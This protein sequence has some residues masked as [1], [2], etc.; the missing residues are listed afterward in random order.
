MRLA[1]ATDPG[2]ARPG[3]FVDDLEVKAGD[4]VIYSSDFEAPTDAAIYNG[5]CREGLQTAQQCTDGWQHVAAADG[6]PAEH[7]Y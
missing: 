6:S 4:R 1:Y 3:W 5:G 7:A 2:L